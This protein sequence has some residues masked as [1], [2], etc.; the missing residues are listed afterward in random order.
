MSYE[1]VVHKPRSPSSHF[2][3][4]MKKRKT[5]TKPIQKKIKKMK[6]L[7]MPIIFS[8][9]ILGGKLLLIFI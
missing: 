5:K 1:G 6:R 4:C 9:Q 3:L 8:Q 7:S 2:F